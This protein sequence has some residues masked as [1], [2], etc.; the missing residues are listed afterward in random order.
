[1]LADLTGNGRRAAVYALRL[2]DRFPVMGGCYLTSLFGYYFFKYDLAVSAEPVIGWINDG[3]DDVYIS[4][5]WVEIDG[6]KIDISFARVEHPDIQRAGAVI[7]IDRVV[8]P[9]YA[10]SYHR[11]RS[12]AAQRV[13]RDATR[14]SPSDRDI[15]ESKEHEHALILSISKDDSRIRDYLDNAPD[16]STYADL[17][18]LIQAP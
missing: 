13:L 17:S 1:M 3:T 11:E 18:R 16:G 6:D 12:K 5:A 2:Y 9:G 10:Y 7:V 8:L 14:R 4:H 15:I